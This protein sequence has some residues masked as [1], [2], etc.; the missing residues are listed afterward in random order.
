M[1][2]CLRPR[3]E[4]GKG[5]EEK[6]EGTWEEGRVNLELVPCCQPRSDRLGW[7]ELLHA[8]FLNFNYY[9][10]EKIRV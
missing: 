7:G 1:L 4:R 5:Q 6:R 9:N 2:G 10:S 3:L 8:A